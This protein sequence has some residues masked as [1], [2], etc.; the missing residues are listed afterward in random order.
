MNE[1]RTQIKTTDIDQ[2]PY[3]SPHI[4]LEITMETQAGSA[5]R[6]PELDLLDEEL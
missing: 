6:F 3:R 5:L 4:V 2:K 1:S